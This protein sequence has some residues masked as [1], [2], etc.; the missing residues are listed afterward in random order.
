MYVGGFA[1]DLELALM[2]LKCSSQYKHS[3]E[4]NQI[5]KLHWFTHAFEHNTKIPIYPPPFEAIP[6]EHGIY[7]LQSEKT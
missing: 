7:R 4:L 3:V 1:V 6:S 2:N 5:S